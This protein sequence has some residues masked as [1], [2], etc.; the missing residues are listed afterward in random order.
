[1]IE[2]ITE[3]I[4]KFGPRPASSQ[5]EKHAQQF[6]AD[7]CKAFTDEVKV[8]EFADYLNA[9]FG[10]LKY[11]CAVFFISLILFYFDLRAVA[12][13]L[14]LLN[15]IAFVL[16]FMTYTVVLQKFPGPLM[17][18][19]NVEATLEPREEVKSTMIVSGHI[20]SV[21]EFKWWYKL[22]QWGSYLTIIAG[23]SMVF[24]PLF[25]L[26]SIIFPGDTWQWW[27]FVIFLVLSP[28]T[29]TYFNMHGSEP[30]DGACDNLSGVA[31]AYEVFKSFANANAKGKSVLKNT[32]LKFVSFGS[33]ETGL[34][35]S[36]NYVLAKRDELKREN[37]HIVNID[38]IRIPE[39]VLVVRRELM[40]GTKHSEE[41]IKGLEESF[42]AKNIPL[43]TG[44]TP[45]GGTDA[46]SF[47]RAG[48]HSTSIVGL[49]MDKLDPTYHTRRDKVEML[50]PVALD[51]VK[52]G[53]IEFIKRWDA[54]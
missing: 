22:G 34:I 43:K 35:G 50:N 13:V 23:V 28:S 26:L 29:V 10:K 31:I 24:F 41:L 30:V 27:G 18:S 12:F 52:N 40:S 37:A 48:F 36:M 53:V 25:C 9:R 49:P 44:N 6:M 14:S 4:Q 15:A 54:K 45:I 19:W 2:L 5:S 39:E 8:L 38:S 47:A 33:E 16:D 11:Y 17:I 21:F 7:K 51:N 3:I 32:R 42:A 46:H 1:M 20:D